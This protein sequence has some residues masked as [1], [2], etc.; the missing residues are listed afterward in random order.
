VP[1]LMPVLTATDWAV[2][3]ALH[4][5]PARSFTFL[6][7]LWLFHELPSFRHPR[8]FTELVHAKKLFDRDQLLT[9]TADKYAVREYV[10][11]RVGAEHLVPLIAVVDDPARLDLGSLPDSFVVKATHGNNATLIVRDKT[12]LNWPASMNAMRNWLDDNWYRYNKEWAYRDIPARL[13]VEEFLDEGGAAANRLQVL[14]LLRQG[15]ARA[16]RPRPF[17]RAPTQPLRRAL[18]QLGRRLS[19]SAPSRASDQ[20]FRVTGDAGDRPGAG[21]GL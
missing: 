10:A 2:L 7:H 9:I 5:L 3:R 18:A 11:D 12:C 20:T 1:T 6:S 15:A 14:R 8:T 4:P 17:H 13:V 19:I 21:F 16:G